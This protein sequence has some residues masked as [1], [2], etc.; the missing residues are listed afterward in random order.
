DPAAAILRRVAVQ[1]LAPPAAERHTDAIVVPR[2]RREVARDQ[3][4]I[5]GP[6]S[7]AQVHDHALIGIVAVDPLEAVGREVALVEGGSRTIEAVDVPHPAA[8][9]FVQRIREHMPLQALVMLPLA[10]LADLP[11]HEEEL[12]AGMSPHVAVEQPQRCELLPLIARHLA[13]ER[14]LAVHHL[15]VRE[16]QH[17]VLAEGI[18]DAEG[19]LVLL[20]LAE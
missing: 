13:D 14:A 7:P 10:P 11:A 17:E 16:R 20:V 15:I 12:L 4:Y 9:A 6:L 18:P 19:E 5:L 3:G 1:A 8:D 2:H